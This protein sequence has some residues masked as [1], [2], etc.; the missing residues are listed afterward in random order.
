[1]TKFFFG[2]AMNIDETNIL[3]LSLL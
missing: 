2:Q 3:Q 1:M